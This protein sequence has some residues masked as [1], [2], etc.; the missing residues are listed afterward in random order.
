[1]I[2]KSI[3]QLGLLSRFV[4]TTG[5]YSTHFSRLSF[6]RAFLRFF[7]LWFWVCVCG[8]RERKRYCFDLKL[9]QAVLSFQFQVCCYF[10]RKLSKQQLITKNGL[11]AAKNLNKTFDVDTKKWIQCSRVFLNSKLEA[12]FSFSSFFIQFISGRV[13]WLYLVASRDFAGQRKPSEKKWKYF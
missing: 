4:I 5:Y 10:H 8:E 11:L 9:F 3:Q 13:G 2:T 12:S 7:A 6:K 1:M